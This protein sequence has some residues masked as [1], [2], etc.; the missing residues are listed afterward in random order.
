MNRK[1]LVTILF[2]LAGCFSS[3]FSQRDAGLW[4]GA[5]IDYEIIDDLELSLSDELRLDRYI[6]NIAK[7]NLDIGVAYDMKKWLSLGA[8]YRFSRENDN[9]LWNNSH[10]Y[11]TDATFQYKSLHF[12]Y[13][14]R[15]RY[16]TQHNAIH[17]SENWNVM[18]HTIRNKVSVDYGILN[19]PWSFQLATEI[20]KPITQPV[21]CD[22]LRIGGGVEYT[23]SKKQKVELSYIYQKEF[24]IAEPEINSIVALGYKYKL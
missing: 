12:K 18:D 20:Y 4:L 9:G 22:K 17:K 7:N 6:T 24:N 19:S 3:V 1:S 21:F 13:A 23:L 2:V 10:R 5:A 8:Y 11:Y 15:I 14:Y 16:Q